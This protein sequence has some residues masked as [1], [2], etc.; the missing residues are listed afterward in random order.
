MAI[1]IAYSFGWETAWVEHALAILPNQPSLF[2]KDRMS[3]AMLE[4]GIGNKKVEALRNWLRALD[5]ARTNG[6]IM[7]LTPYGRA[8]AEVDRTL[9]EA[10]TFWLLHLQLALPARDAQQTHDLWQWYASAV[11]PDG[12][13]QVD[14]REGFQLTLPD[15][16]ES[17]LKNG[18]S[19][20]LGSLRNTP[21]GEMGLLETGEKGR[22]YRRAANI[23]PFNSAVL[24]MAVAR[25]MARLGRSS[26][27]FSELTDS[28]G[29]ARILSLPLS[30]AVRVL[31][32][33][34]RQ[35]GSHGVRVSQTAGLDT[36]WLD[37]IDPLYWYL[38]AHGEA[39][40]RPLDPGAAANLLSS[41]TEG[42]VSDDVT[43]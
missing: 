27:A 6:A 5:L 18:V 37:Q 14:L 24:V 2:H 39:T 26:L 20:L 4:F 7:K 21:L 17:A 23:E 41:V 40:G 36:V 43:P 19:E 15:V 12:F 25:Q 10:T 35:F 13:T 3:D 31:G 8:V 11:F 9:R 29:A 16:K 33:A 38:V 28:G 30:V 34:V 32:L 22:C 42:G 1:S